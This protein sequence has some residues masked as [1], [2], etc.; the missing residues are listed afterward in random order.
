[1]DDLAL[2]DH[3]FLFEALGEDRIAQVNR[4]AFSDERGE[5]RLFIGLLR[6]IGLIG[7]HLHVDPASDRGGERIADLRVAEV[8][9]AQPDFGSS[10]PKWA[11]LQSGVL[12]T[13][14]ALVLRT[15]ISSLI[16]RPAFTN[17]T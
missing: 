4:D 15:S 17:T 3:Q 6:I 16:M 8:A 13:Q 9:D 5:L 1:L 14:C 10:L 11:R 7:D 2:V 12:E